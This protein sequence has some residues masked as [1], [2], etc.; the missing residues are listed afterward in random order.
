[1]RMEVEICLWEEAE[2]VMTLQF[3]K[4]KKRKKRDDIPSRARGLCIMLAGARPV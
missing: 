4:K 2:Y 1:M 3:K